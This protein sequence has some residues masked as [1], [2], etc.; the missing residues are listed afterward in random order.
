LNFG[1]F[2]GDPEILIDERFSWN[3]SGRK[4]E[5]SS[6]D[7][8]NLGKICKF[9]SEI[10]G[11]KLWKIA[12]ILAFFVSLTSCYTYPVGQIFTIL[13]AIKVGVGLNNPCNFE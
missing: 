5:L 3:S 10:R 2:W 6:A 7:G 8:A 4:R 11:V 1:K 12:R 13:R 9:F